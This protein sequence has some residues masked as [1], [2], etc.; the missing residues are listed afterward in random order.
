M[1]SRTSFLTLLAAAALSARGGSAASG[2]EVF[3]VAIFRFA[4]EHVDD[5]IAAFRAIAS[6]TRQESGNLRYD[7]YR[8]TD[9]DLEFYIAEHWASQAALAAHERTEA[10][11]HF[12][13][14]VLMKHATLHEAV[15]ARTFD[16]A[17]GSR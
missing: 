12:G 8:G 7:I 10:F 11:I 17:Q 3:H 2:D 15:T 14:G 4:K 5:A 6:A 9:D 1:I 13:Q 16:V